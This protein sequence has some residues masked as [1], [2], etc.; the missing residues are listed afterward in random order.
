ME[1]LLLS[2]ASFLKAFYLRIDVL[3]EILYKKI[4]TKRL[5][6]PRKSTTTHIAPVT[7]V[8]FCIIFH[9]YETLITIHKK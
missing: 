7:T 6:A 3:K 1:W 2:Y 4:H 8:L 5:P 9:Y